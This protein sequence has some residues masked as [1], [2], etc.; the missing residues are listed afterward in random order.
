MRAFAEEHGIIRDGAKT[1]A[2]WSKVEK[3]VQEMRRAL[4]KHFGLANGDPIPFVDGTGYKALF[5][6][7][8][9]PSFHT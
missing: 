3:R 9:S 1:G 2:A 5:K 7:G 6:I 4:R 8:C